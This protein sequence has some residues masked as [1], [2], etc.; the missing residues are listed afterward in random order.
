MRLWLASAMLKK[1]ADM[2]RARVLARWIAARIIESPWLMAT[3]AL[4]L[5]VTTTS[6]WGNYALND[7]WTYAHLAKRLAETGR[8]QL[9]A[10]QNASAIG[11]TLVA[12]GVVRLF[13]FSHVALRLL[14]IAVA[15]I[16]LWGVDRLLQHVVPQKPLRLMALLL[17]ALNPIYFYLAT[18]FMNE[19]YGWVPAVLA[20]VL[21]FW[22]RSRLAHDEDRLIAPWV[23]V[24][25]AILAGS[26]FWTRQL[27][28]LVY[29]ALLTGTILRFLILKRWRAIWRAVPALMVATAVFV[30]A[31]WSYL[32]WARATGNFRPEFS[33]R[34]N[35]LG[36]IDGRTYG[37]QLGSALVYM[38]GFFLPLLALFRWRSKHRWLLDLG[39]A[40]FVILALVSAHLFET[41]STVDFGNGTDWI[42][43]VFPFICNIVYNAGV[44]P[45]TLD[46]VFFGNA[47]KPVWQKYVW[48]SLE[49]VLVVSSALF[50]LVCAAVVRAARGASTSSSVEVLLFSGALVLGSMIAIVQTHQIEMVDRYYLPLILGL[51]VLVPG[52]LATARPRGPGKYDVV[53]FIALFAPIALF[54]VLGVHDEFRWS[55]ARQQMIEVAMSLGGTRATVQAGYERNCWLKYEGLS[56]RELACEGGCRCAQHGF[57][58]VDDRWRVGTSI[59]PGYRQVATA[60]PNYWLASGP[61]VLLTRRDAP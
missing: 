46:D 6:P 39:G 40:S 21:W 31:I 15:C 28:I 18:T 33:E 10:P 20:V 35:H 36:K 23:A 11:Q 60:H 5:A 14:T 4:L 26:S 8:I 29:P 16:G 17:L 58:C 27:C 59:S 7:D 43:R 49:V 37:L 57:C 2:A 25:V 47:P 53:K 19:L 48:A 34:I 42:H 41:L 32:W 44:G 24:C 56:P 3:L 38:T 55:D 13:G 45:I 51:A 30:L 9:D 52:A 12:A 50:S 61:A 54:S 22:D 1:R